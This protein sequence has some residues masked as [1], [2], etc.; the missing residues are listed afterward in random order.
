M[1][2]ENINLG[3]NFIILLL[4]QMLLFNKI[5]AFGDLNP[6]VYLLF[7][8][9]YP[10]DRSQTGFITAA[11][12]LGFFIDFLSQGS[13]AHTL[14]ALT[15]AFVRPFAIRQAFGSNIEIPPYLQEDPRMLNRWLLIVELILIHHFIYFTV[16]FWD[17]T[18][19]FSILKNSFNTF[20]MSL[21]LIA[22]LIN[23]YPTKR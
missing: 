12:L 3:I 5:N 7:F 23:F 15:V 9:H 17:I 4:A 19:I 13:G 14:G 6:M 1:I 2:R 21:I 16:V 18:H 22:L 8:I 20:F 10:T 11:F